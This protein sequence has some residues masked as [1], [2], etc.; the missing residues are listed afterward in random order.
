MFNIPKY[1]AGTPESLQAY[2]DS[3]AK[4]MESDLPTKRADYLDPED[5]P[6]DIPRL[7]EMQGD[8]A[9]IS[10]KGSL[11]NSDSWMN[12]FT[13]AVSYS[14]IRAALI[15]AVNSDRVKAIAL[16]IQSG[17]GSVS[18]LADTA[19]LIKTID[20]KVKPVYAYGDSLIASAAYRL[21]ISARSLQIG[22][23]TESGSI[24]VVMVHHE[25]T[26]MMEND[27]ITATVIRS[28]KWKLL[29]SQYEK[30]SELAESTLQAQVDQLNAL[31]VEYVASCRGKSAAVVEA[32]MGGGRI[33][34]GQ[35]AVDVGLVDG[36]TNFDSFMSSIALG[37]DKANQRPQYGAI[38]TKGAS[39]ATALTDQ[40][41]ADAA[42]AKATADLSAATAATAAAAVFTELVAA[43]AANSEV[44][45]LLQEQLAT[46]Q[47][48]VLAL[49]VETQTLKTANAALEAQGEKLRPAVRAA[50]SNLRVALGGSATGIEALNDDGLMAEHAN[51]S[52]QFTSKFPAGG[53]AAVS[54]TASAEKA[55]EAEDFLR[56]ARLAAT[57]PT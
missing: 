22:R 12:Y 54:S 38:L 5:D 17:G 36:V 13:G 47:A 8:V 9:V 44:V 23:E 53:V 7:L 2:L 51:L 4:L 50:V 32:T 15:W 3:V 16:D 14:S 25:I 21:G 20:T 31:F 34:I 6:T 19:D 52:A 41:I 1:W 48:Q 29:G 30:L 40:Q 45:A 18:G 37:I 26:K 39:V 11:T 27:G 42:A 55:S 57:R 24:G 10:I 33:F 28:G 43:P 49:S 46:A 35:S 56:K